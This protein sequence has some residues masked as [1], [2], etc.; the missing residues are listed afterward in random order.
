MKRLRIT[1][2][3]LADT[4]DCCATDDCGCKSSKDRAI[5][6]TIT[7]TADSGPRRTESPYVSVPQNYS[8]KNMPAYAPSYTP[9]ALPQVV[10]APPSAP[11]TRPP[12]PRTPAVVQVPYEETPSACREVSYPAPEW[13]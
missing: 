5:N 6:I 7:N 2:Q 10:P 13:Q 9:V 12:A 1:P 4:D 3:G 8:Y 11:T